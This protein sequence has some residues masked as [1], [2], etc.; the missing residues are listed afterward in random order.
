MFNKI[1]RKVVIA[2]GFPDKARKDDYNEKGQV[3][4]IRIFL[5]RCVSFHGGFFK[6]QSFTVN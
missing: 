4:I 1:R 5:N 6:I 3:I 2:T